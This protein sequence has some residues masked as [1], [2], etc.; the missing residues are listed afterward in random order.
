MLVEGA[1]GAFLAAAAILLLH[2]E[3][4]RAGPEAPKPRRLNLRPMG[5]PFIRGRLLLLLKVRQMLV[6]LGLLELSTKLTLFR[7]M[8]AFLLHLKLLSN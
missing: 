6:G 8:L 2:F 5:R 7:T 4:T 3:N 1:F